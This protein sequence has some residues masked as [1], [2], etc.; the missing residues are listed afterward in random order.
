VTRFIGL[1]AICFAGFAHGADAPK[2]TPQPGY[3]TA[4][5]RESVFDMARVAVESA[6]ISNWLSEKYAALDE[7]RKERMRE[8]L[9]YLIDSYIAQKYREEGAILSRK[10]DFMLETLFAWAE[11]LGVYGGNLVHAAVKDPKG[12]GE[13]LVPD[14]PLLPAM[15]LSLRGDLFNLKA[16]GWEVAF[17]YYFMIGRVGNVPNAGGK[18]AEMVIIS[19]GAAKDKSTTGHSQATLMVV[20]SAGGEL[21]PFKAF[22]EKLIPIS[23]GDERVELGVRGLTSQRNFDDK[24]QLHREL[25]AWKTPQ[26]VIAVAYLGNEGTYQWNREHFLD[27]LRALRTE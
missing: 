10:P 16:D 14:L 22:W 24:L 7:P 18:P 3:S 6:T 4:P 25:V 17:P 2:E 26:G 1:L 15:N 11:P 9:Y 13:A 27:F 5:L 12:Q 8:R 19:T 20:Y 23:A 21:A